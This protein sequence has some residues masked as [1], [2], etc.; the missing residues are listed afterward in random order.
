MARLS[1]HVLDTSRG[2]P[3]AGVA[4]R[5][6]ALG[7]QRELIASAVT[8][9]DGRTAEPLLSGVYGGDPAQL[10]VSAAD[11]FSARRSAPVSSA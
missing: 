5:L 10:S 4:V 3:A 11:Q 2:K 8:N 9:A 6:Y 7:Q 1:T